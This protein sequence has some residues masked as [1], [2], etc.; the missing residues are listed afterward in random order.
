M[1]FLVFDRAQDPLDEDIVPP[2]P[3]TVHAD[4]DV[5]GFDEVCELDRR[6]LVRIR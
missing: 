3:F 5:V 6:E 2:S 4:L 1:D